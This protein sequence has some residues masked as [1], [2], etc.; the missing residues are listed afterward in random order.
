[1][2]STYPRGRTCQRLAERRRQ[3]P[4]RAVRVAETPSPSQVQIR[5]VHQPDLGVGVA[6]V[7]AFA[8]RPRWDR[9]AY[10]VWLA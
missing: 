9:R 10:L 2:R 5:E 1:M 4:V 8:I 7:R 6:L 3:K